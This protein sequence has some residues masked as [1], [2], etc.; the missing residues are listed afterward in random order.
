[1]FGQRHLVLNVGPVVAR[2]S[3]LVMLTIQYR[4]GPRR[5]VALITTPLSASRTHLIATSRRSRAAARS[6]R[7]ATAIPCHRPAP[8]VISTC[9]GKIARRMPTGATG[10]TVRGLP[11]FTKRNVH[12][13]V[14]SAHSGGVVRLRIT[15]TVVF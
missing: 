14:S 4:D 7:C 9:R 1:M 11:E 15:K 5:G 3:R 13:V 8:A 6:P 12:P 2:H 10:F